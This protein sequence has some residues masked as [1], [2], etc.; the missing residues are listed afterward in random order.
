MTCIRYNTLLDGVFGA[1]TR[2]HEAVQRLSRLAGRGRPE[3]FR[4]AMLECKTCASVCR[5]AVAAFKAHQSDHGCHSE[6]GYAR[7]RTRALRHL[8]HP[9]PSS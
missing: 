9:V 3:L 6:R 1:S 8:P 7:R 2:Y 5:R 4:K